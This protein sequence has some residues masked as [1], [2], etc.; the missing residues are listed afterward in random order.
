MEHQ[1]GRAGLDQGDRIAAAVP[2]TGDSVDLGVQAQ[3]P[4]PVGDE[5]G[6]VE[7]DACDRAGRGEH[8]AGER[9]IAER[10]LAVGDGVERRIGRDRDVGMRIVEVCDRV[11]DRAE[12]VHGRRVA[13]LRMAV[14]RATRAAGRIVRGIA[15]PRQTA[16]GA[17]HARRVAQTQLERIPPLAFCGSEGA[18]GQGVVH[19]VVEHGLTADDQMALSL[20]ASKNEATPLGPTWNSPV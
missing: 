3:R 16:I 19:R 2:P 4:G 5:R 17:G 10:G 9:Q 8:S 13:V 7:V 6:L 12:P 15:E 20:M 11:L 18:G 14:E 1:V